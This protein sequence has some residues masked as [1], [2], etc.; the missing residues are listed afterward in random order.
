M[1]AGLAPA[2]SAPSLEDEERLEQDFTDPLTTLPQLIVRES[3]TPA[4]YGPCTPL[5]CFRDY[6]TNQLVVRPLIPV[7]HPGHCH[8]SLN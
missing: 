3:Y 1:A 6:Q 5:A 8:R 7:S 2:E 4:N